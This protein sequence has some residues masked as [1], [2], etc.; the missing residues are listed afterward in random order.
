MGGLLSVYLPALIFGLEWVFFLLSV[1]RTRS[2]QDQRDPGSEPAASLHTPGGKIAL[3]AKGEI[4]SLSCLLENAVKG[5]LSSSAK[6]PPRRSCSVK[7]TW[8]LQG[9]RRWGL[10]CSPGSFSSGASGQW[11][12]L[13]GQVRR[14]PPK[15]FRSQSL[16]R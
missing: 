1:W 7:V 2:G 13:T 15:Y 3:G 8:P 9:C 12:I 11:F 14:P 16:Q 10:G 5:V 6:L 4:P